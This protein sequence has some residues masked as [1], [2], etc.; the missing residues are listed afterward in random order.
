MSSA[1]K[2]DVET[3]RGARIVATA[4]IT[5]VTLALLLLTTVVSGYWLAYTSG[6]ARATA[7]SPAPSYRVVDEQVPPDQ[8]PAPYQTPAADQMPASGMPPAAAPQPG[9]PSNPE[10]SSP[11]ANEQRLF[12][13]R[14][15]LETLDARELVRQG[16]LP[17]W[18]RK[19]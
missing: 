11:S 19:E 18:D 16:A 15:A 5:A 14:H 2:V 3:P 13:S 12:K 8:G 10:D 17:K 6:P 4:A 7:A 9:A 1:R